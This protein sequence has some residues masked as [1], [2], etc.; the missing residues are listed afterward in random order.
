MTTLNE[1]VRPYARHSIPDYGYPKKN[2][3]RGGQNGLWGRRLHQER[4]PALHHHPRR[5]PSAQRVHLFGA[6][7]CRRAG[8]PGHGPV[9]ALH[10]DPHPDDRGHG[11]RRHCRA[12]LRA[13]AHQYHPLRLPPLSHPAVPGHGTLPGLPGRLLPPGVPQG[14]HYRHQWPQP[15]RPEEV[16]QMRQVR[17]GLPL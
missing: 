4:G 11:P 10:P 5:Q 7:H 9:P 17:Q 6:G 15:H 12:V 2:L 16:H 3:H 13:P 14:R 8:P 1:E